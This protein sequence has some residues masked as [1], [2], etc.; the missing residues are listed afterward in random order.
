M[1]SVIDEQELRIIGHKEA[2]FR[3][4]QRNRESAPRFEYSPFTMFRLI[5]LRR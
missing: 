4:N 5:S 1:P 3:A 2:I